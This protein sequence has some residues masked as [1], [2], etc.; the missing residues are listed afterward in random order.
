MKSHES[1]PPAGV[2]GEGVDEPALRA[3]FNV[4]ERAGDGDNARRRRMVVAG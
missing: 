2:A 3:H 4:R 1:P